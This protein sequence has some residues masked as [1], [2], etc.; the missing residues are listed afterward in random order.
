MLRDSITLPSGS[1]IATLILLLTSLPQ[2]NQD[3]PYTSGH[4]YHLKTLAEYIIRCAQVHMSHVHK[5]CGH[6]TTGH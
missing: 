6:H 3:Y 4:Q 5:Q 1:V 2:G